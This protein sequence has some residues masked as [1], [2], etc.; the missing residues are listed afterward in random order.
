MSEI[1]T[2]GGRSVCGCDHEAPRLATLRSTV[3]CQELARFY[4]VPNM[5][6]EGIIDQ[7]PVELFDHR[8][9]KL[10]G[11]DSDSRI[12]NVPMPIDD[13]PSLTDDLFGQ[14]ARR[15]MNRFLSRSDKDFQYRLQMRMVPT[16]LLLSFVREI[17]ICCTSGICSKN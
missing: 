3:F 4:R 6:A 11:Y 5:S 9:G 10:F 8:T 1:F 15:S 17:N 16:V 7:I 13:D 12:S 2:P 14:D